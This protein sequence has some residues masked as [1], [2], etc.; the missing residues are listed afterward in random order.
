VGGGAPGGGGGGGGGGGNAGDPSWDALF[1][2]AGQLVEDGWIAEVAIPFKSLRYPG[3]G[4]GERHRWGFQ[5]E[6][7]IESKNES[8]VW[9]PISRAIPA[10]L[11]QMGVLEGMTDLSTSRNLELLPTFTAVQASR[12][13]T[14]TG[15]QVTDT[16]PAGGMNV[17]YGV[18]PTLI[19]DF[20]FNPDFS[21]IESDRQQIEVNQRFPV[22]YP[23]LRPFF[24]EGQEIYGIQG[25]ATFVHTRTIVDPKYG[26]KLTGKAGKTSIGIL[27]AND[28]APGRVDDAADPLYGTAAQVFMGRARYDL[29]PESSIG[30]IFTSRDVLDSYSRLAGVDGAF[31][32]LRSYRVSFGA[33]FS[34]R[35]GLDGVRQTGP[36]LN[37]DFAAQGRNLSYSV[38]HNQIHPEF[39]TDLG[40]VRRVDQKQTTANIQYRWYPEHWITNWGPRFEYERILDYEGVKQDGVYTTGVNF[41]FARNMMLNANLNR[42]TER[43]LGIDFE[44]TR[45]S[46]FGN[47]NAIRLIGFGGGYNDGDQVRF[48][49]DPYL[50]KSAGLNFFANIRPVSRLQVQ[51]NLNRSTF[52]DVRTDT[53]EFDI[54]I[55]RA[56]TSYQMTD[57]LT[58]RNILDHNTYDRTVGAN[59]L[60]TYRV[61]SGTV[62]YL[63]YD[64]RYRQGDR[65][66]ESPFPTAQYQ[67]TNKAI[68]TKLQYLLRY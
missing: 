1:A 32:F 38:G 42:S 31:R 8:I 34:D 18:T 4:N 11:T 22:F 12:L 10:F 6:R 54:K 60:M 64:D 51:L 28:E 20:T 67:R 23:E 21:Q 5:I 7:S 24:L 58:I 66:E 45:Y 9:A 36:S 25:P 15:G 13:D 43:Y 61:N 68:F 27:A 49:D 3:R 35:Q 30:A 37:L 44:K 50:G 26:V 29:Y 39:G 47:V 40:F 41:Q 59:L 56:Q 48:V 63:G 55:I 2:S 14:D 16:S 46:F 62:F 57:R 52:T 33:I 19:L 65:I 53:E 17:K